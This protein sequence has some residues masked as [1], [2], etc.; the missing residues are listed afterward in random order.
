MVFDSQSPVAHVK[1]P[2][3]S[4][5][6]SVLPDMRPYHDDGACRA[7]ASPLPRVK[8]VVVSCDFHEKITGQTVWLHLFSMV[9]IL[10]DKTPAKK[11]KVN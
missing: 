9:R 4:F 3:E 11:I 1:F 2:V 5:E 7:R 10:I 6:Q 8:P